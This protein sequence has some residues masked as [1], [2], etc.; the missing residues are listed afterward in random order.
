MGSRSDSCEKF[1]VSDESR[2]ASELSVSVQDVIAATVAETPASPLYVNRLLSRTTAPHGLTT[3]EIKRLFGGVH[4]MAKRQRQ[5][6]FATLGDGLQD[7]S[8]GEARDIAEVFLKALVTEQKDRGLPQDWLLVWEC[9]GGL[10]CHIIFIG[11]RAIVER[12]SRSDRFGQHLHVRWAYDVSGLCP[13]LSKERTSQ[14][15]FGIG[16]FIG[17]GRKRG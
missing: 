14:A 5:M 3:A 12:L 4:C 10:H 7:M 1:L 9:S 15:Q 6:F 13:Y 8:T 11:N 2:L 16:A 17:G